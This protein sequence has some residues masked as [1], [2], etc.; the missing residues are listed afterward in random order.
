MICSLILGLFVAILL[1]RHRQVLHRRVR[2]CHVRDR[3]RMRPALNPYRRRPIRVASLLLF[4]VPAWSQNLEPCTLTTVVGGVVPAP[5]GDGGPAVQAGLPDGVSAFAVSGEDLYIGG[6][7]SIRRI[8]G[9]IIETI[10][11]TGESGFRGDG[12][13][14]S[15]AQFDNIRALAFRANGELL[16]A[17]ASNRRIRQIDSEGIVTTIAGNGEFEPPVEGAIASQSSAG[18]TQGLAVDSLDRVY[19]TSS[20]FVFRIE[21]DGRLNRFAGRIGDPFDDGDPKPAIQARLADASKLVIDRSDNV[22]IL[23]RN[24]H[25]IRRVDSTGTI[26]MFAGTGTFGTGADGIPAIESSLSLPAD[27]SLDGRGRLYIADHG[28]ARYRRVDE[29]GVV[30][31]VDGGGGAGVMATD[32]AGRIYHRSLTG[33]MSRTFGGPTV[34]VVAG[35]DAPSDGVP[36]PLAILRGAAGV[37]LSPD[38]RLFVAEPERRRLLVKERNGLVRVYAGSGLGPSGILPTAIGENGPARGVSLWRPSSLAIDAS[39]NVYLGDIFRHSVYQ[40]DRQGILRRV[41][42]TNERGVSA[43]S[44]PATDIPLFDP[45]SLAVD[46]FSNLYIADRD[47]PRGGGIKLRTPDGLMRHISMIQ[48]ATAVAVGPLGDLFVGN[49]SV[50]VGGTIVH[51]APDGTE[52]IIAGGGRDL[53]AGPVPAT[54][55]ELPYILDLVSDSAGNL[56]FGSEWRVQVMRTDGNVVTLAGAGPVDGFSPDGSPAATASVR[57]AFGV[58]LDHQGNVYFTETPIDRPA[59][60]RMIVDGQACAGV[61]N[62]PSFSAAGVVSAAS[63][64]SGAVSPGEI[65]SVFGRNLG[66]VSGVQLQIE[67]NGLVSTRPAELQVLFDGNP[68]PVVFGSAFQLSAVAPFA[69]SGVATTDLQVV[70]NGKTSGPVRLDVV[71]A[72]PA[73]FTLNG[74]GVGPAAV[75][76]QDGSVNTVENPA[77]PGEIIVLFGTG[78]GETSPRSIDGT[79]AADILPR[80]VLPVEL[81]VAGRPQPL[82]YAGAAP[83]LIAGVIQ[84]NAQLSLDVPA[85]PAIPTTL[86]VGPW[87]SPEG[88]TVAIGSPR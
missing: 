52:T 1:V 20:D 31:S 53:T 13:P 58:A 79:L 68:A 37:A 3:A 22:Y 80:P 26:R 47:V 42:G 76:N 67:E 75:L 71:D 50:P 86:K 9:G 30:S 63:F 2:H 60:V 28:N 45:F 11:G 33:I 48:P 16:V 35:P 21:A 7:S 41:A 23:E 27:I 78:Q 6:Q 43:E 65:I 32:T 74:S 12:G 61:E 5:N 83:G 25:S 14:A 82:T 85:G 72:R 66:P 19:F 64:Q 81:R 40:I 38:G 39:G 17:D 24:R 8:R 56:Y 51:L 88:T 73:L 29:A 70:Y 49:F 62:T 87:E 15:E 55:A 46:L 36:A 34:E 10:A 57:R 69:L 54:D 59:L 4:A 44:G 77:R 18:F 84:V